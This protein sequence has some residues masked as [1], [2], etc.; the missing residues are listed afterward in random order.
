MLEPS[1]RFLTIVLATGSAVLL[2]AIGI[3]ERMGDRVLGQAT[4][5]TLQSVI[6]VA[7]SP[8]PSQSP[9]P[10]GPNWKRLDTMSA[11]GDPHFPDP[12]VPPQPLPTLPPAPKVTAT[13]FV[14]ATPTPNPNIPIWRRQR[15]MPTAIP[16]AFASPVES[17]PPP[18]R[19]AGRA[20]PAPP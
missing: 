11:A 17:P 15:P 19:G 18:E 1:R 2:V 14:P 8:T 6:P 4:E 16:T 20:S 10:L 9:G 13:P 3:G 12:R 5:Q 7:A